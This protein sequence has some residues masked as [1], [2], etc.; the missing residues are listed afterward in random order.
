MTQIEELTKENEALKEENARLTYSVGELLKKIEEYRVALEIKEQNDMKKRYIKE[1]SATVKKLME[2]V[3]DMPISVRSKNILFAAG[4][5]TLG[6]IVKYQK[7]DLIKF[8]NCGR[9][10][11]MEITDL[12]NNSG[13]SWGMNVD[14]IIEADMKEYLE[15]KAVE[16]K[17]K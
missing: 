7:Y 5:L 9:K 15:K 3:D 14:D 11:I 4:C 1:A 17:K 13:L 2:K 10:T 8:R 6:D 16:N 12:V